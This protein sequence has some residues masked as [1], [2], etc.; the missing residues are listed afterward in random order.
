VPPRPFQQLPFDELPDLP[1][2]AHGHFRSQRV[3]AVLDSRG[4]GKLSVHYRV[5][6]SGPPLLLVHGLMTSSYS[7]RYVIEPLAHRFTVYAPDLPGSGR[8]AKPDASYHPDALAD[9]IG[10]FLRQ[11]GI[12]GCPTI[13]NSLGGYLCMRLALRD[14]GAMSRLVNLHS[15]GVPLARLHALRFALSL[16]GSARLLAALVAR[17][18]ERWVHRN[19]HYYDETLKSREETVEYAEPLT[20]P[21]GVNAFTRIL[22]ETLDPRH[23]AAFTTELAA[24]RARAEPFPVPLQ[25]V[26]VP[27]DPM[28]PP[29]VGDKLRALVPSADFVPLDHAS[30][31]AHVDNPAGFLAVALPFLTGEA[32]RAAG[33]DS[34][35][36]RA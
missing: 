5:Q 11:V 33:P 19:V 3:D 12:R 7:W 1:R 35:R 13:G 31:F 9:W 34:A 6:G 21:E 23:M 32:A 4:F 25:L 26:Y 8:T 28:V 2:V 17:D 18:P 29:A 22:R 16:P 36:H 15:P 14:G 27:R 10:D 24:R 30:H 20:T